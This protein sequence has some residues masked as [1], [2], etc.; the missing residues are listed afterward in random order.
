MTPLAHWYDI[1]DSHIILELQNEVIHEVLHNRYYLIKWAPMHEQVTLF[2]KLLSHIFEHYTEVQDNG[3]ISDEDI[4]IYPE[5]FIPR[6]HMMPIGLQEPALLQQLATP[7][8]SPCRETEPRL[9]Q[10]LHHIRRVLFPSVTEP[11]DEPMPLDNINLEDKNVHILND[12]PDWFEEP[13][14]DRHLYIHDEHQDGREHFRLPPCPDSIVPIGA[15]DSPSGFM[16]LQDIEDM[17]I[18]VDVDFSSDDELPDLI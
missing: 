5:I 10:D 18:L 7:H 16:S 3:Y 14:P 15:N 1:I 8:K 2:R 6:P 13:S 9:E 11:E 17:N 12:S 4:E